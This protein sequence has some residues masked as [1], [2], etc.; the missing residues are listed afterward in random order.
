MKIAIF[1]LARSGLSAFRFLTQKTDH[2]VFLVNQGAPTTW[3]C[4]QDI[5]DNIS[6]DHC[7]DQSDAEDLFTQMD[8]I[9][10][11]PG[12]PREHKVLEKAL[13][14]NVELISEIEFAYRH[15]DIP[16]IGITGTNGK[17]TTTTMIGEVLKMAGKRPFVCGNIGRPYSELLL[18]KDNYDYA[19]VELSSFQ[20]ESIKDFHPQ[21][22]LMINIT[23]SHGE[24]YTKFDSYKNAK[25]EIFKNQTTEDFVLINRDLDSTDLKAKVHHIKPLKEFDY[26]NSKLVG[27]H[28]EMN[29]YCAYKVCEFLNISNLD[30]IFQEFIDK[31]NGVEFRLQFIKKYNDLNIYNDGKSTNDAATFAAVKSFPKTQNLYLALGGQPRSDSTTLNST[32]KGC[33]ITKILAFGDAKDLIERSMSAEFEVVKL[34]TLEDLFQF[35]K[36][37]KL[38]GNLLFSPAFPSFDQYENYEKRGEHFTELALGLNK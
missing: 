16:I 25:Y 2:E 18:E 12:I 7:F 38:S 24:R 10:L 33:H 32:L 19:I 29:F 27:S 21:I 8:Q 11:S 4:Y 9:I 36:N 28:N 14:K 17:T 6:L 31:F 3:A 22:A 37:E 20:L 30:K 13:G 5:K 34:N 26:S 23:P 15:S 1:G 35:I